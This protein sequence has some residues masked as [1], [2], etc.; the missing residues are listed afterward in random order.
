MFWNTVLTPAP[1]S[2]IPCSIRHLTPAKSTNHCKSLTTSG[3]SQKTRFCAPHPVI[4]KPIGKTI[5]PGTMLA[6]VQR[7][8]VE[9]FVAQKKITTDTDAI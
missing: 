9:L 7:Q 2:A 5:V 3:T 8:R 4:S 6:E 1:T